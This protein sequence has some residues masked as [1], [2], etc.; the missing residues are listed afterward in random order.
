[1][2]GA[3]RHIRPAPTA[4]FIG[5]QEKAR[6]PFVLTII[7]IP[8]RNTISPAGANRRSSPK[9][10]QSASVTISCGSSDIRTPSPIAAVS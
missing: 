9:A 7:T 6:P 3:G 2:V 4:E 5:G 8:I 10:A 1:V